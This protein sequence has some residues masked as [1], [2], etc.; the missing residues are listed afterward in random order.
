MPHRFASR[1]KQRRKRRQAKKAPM[2]SKVAIRNIVDN[3]LNKRIEKKYFQPESGFFEIDGSAVITL[4]TLY[5]LGTSETQM[6][7]DGVTQGDGQGQRIGSR[8]TM[9]S[10]RLNWLDYSLDSQY[11]LLVVYFP[12]S[13]G[14]DFAAALGNNFINQF[15]PSKK[16]FG[17][18]YKVLYDHIH[19]LDASERLNALRKISLPVKGLTVQYDDDTTTIS[20]GNVRFYI[21]TSPAA[22]GGVIGDFQG[23][24][25]MVYTDA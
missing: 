9:M 18:E 13:D 21:G 14:S 3:V 24:S 5:D 16:D 25:K 1:H 4:G 7:L 8:I 6:D 10:W 22:N 2:A 11:R 20:G 15:L 17:Q 12:H 23:V 19:T